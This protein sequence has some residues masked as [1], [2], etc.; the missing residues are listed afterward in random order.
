MSLVRRLLL[1]FFVCASVARAGLF[2]E[3]AQADHEGIPEVSITKLRAFLSE[4]QE[5]GLAKKAKLLLARCLIETRQAEEAL[6]LLSEPGF[7]GTEATDLKAQASLRLRRWDLAESFFRQQLAEEPK[8]RSD[9]LL[10]LAEAQ[11]GAGQLDSAL[12]TLQPL[13]SKNTPLDSR[14]ALLAAEVNL[15]RSDVAA[16]KDLLARMNANSKRNQFER[17]CL[18][19]EIALQEHNLDAAEEAFSQVLAIQEGRTGRTIA[20]AQL[21]LVRV[22]AA[23]QEFEEA[24]AAIEKLIADQPRSLVLPELFETLFEVYSNEA[25]PSLSELTRWSQE[26]PK[27]S[28][29]DRP[30]YAYYYLGKLQLQEGLNEKARETWQELLRRFPDHRVASEGAAELAREKIRAADFKGAAA[31]IEKVLSSGNNQSGLLALLQLLAEAYVHEGNFS[32]AREIF[33]DLAKRDKTSSQ[34]ALFNAAICGLRL[35]DEA[36]FEAAVA[37]LRRTNPPPELLGDLAFEQGL[38]QAKAAKASADETLRRFLTDFAGHPKIPEAHLILAEIR[39]TEQPADPAAAQEE[40]KEIQTQDVALREK[41]DRLRFF[42]A[43]NDPKQSAQNVLR[44]ADE[45]FQKYPTSPVRAEIRVKLGE[46]YF[47]QNDYPNAQTQF[48]LVREEQPDSPLVET[49]LFLAGEAARKSLNPTSL[50]RA[51]T[52]FEDVCNLGGPL[53]YQARLEQALTKRQNHQENEAIVLLGDLLNQSPPPEIRYEALDAKGEAEFTLAAQDQSFYDRAIGTFSQLAASDNLP[54]EWKQRALYKKGK[55]LEK[56]KKFDDALAAYYDALALQGASGDQLWFYR[57]GFDA[58]QILEDRRAWS[59][60]GAVYEKLA[61]TRGAR[62]NE[63]KNR[64]DRLRLEHFL[65]PE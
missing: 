51:I 33:L 8:V 55:C 12:A 20:V 26:D 61:N 31:D 57:S 5:P 52:L 40:L 22:L 18:E 32:A 45:F 17:L 47:R 27:T 23:K 64:L 65:W 56:L 29:P 63:A 15:Q 37:D 6:Q 41:A 48:E 9:S 62:S 16:A 34:G 53:R 30:A 3:A 21:G 35:G 24:E 19:G 42:I 1:F 10:G 7:D 25:N 44:L 54:L 2:E 58:A 28:G 43:A 38:L 14:A 59:S 60:A 39:M 50:D 11:R 13:I 46:F 36:G 49:A 4:N